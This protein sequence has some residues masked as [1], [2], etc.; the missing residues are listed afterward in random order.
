M[1]EVSVCTVETVEIA[2]HTMDGELARRFFIFD[3]AAGLIQFAVPDQ[4]LR[5]EPDHT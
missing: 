2:G 1:E 5:L 4:V 3:G